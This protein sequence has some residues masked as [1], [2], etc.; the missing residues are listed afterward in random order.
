MYKFETYSLINMRH[1]L[2][3]HACLFAR[4]FEIIKGYVKILLQGDFL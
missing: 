1:F 3:K 2:I 4:F